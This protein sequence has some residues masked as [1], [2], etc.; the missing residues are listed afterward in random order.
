MLSRAYV[1]LIQNFVHIFIPFASVVFKNTFACFSD[2]NDDTFPPFQGIYSQSSCWERCWVDSQLN[3]DSFPFFNFLDWTS[4]SWDKLISVSR[5]SDEWWWCWSNWSRKRI[6]QIESNLHQAFDGLWSLH[7]Y[8]VNDFIRI[9]P[10]SWHAPQ[11]LKMLRIFWKTSHPPKKGPPDP[12]K[13][14]N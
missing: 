7:M 12:P 3:S 13:S 9:S 1:C 6:L 10:W 2:D 5:Q 14:E 4:E 11:I 8:K